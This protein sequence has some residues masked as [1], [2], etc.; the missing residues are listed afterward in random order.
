[1]SIKP[2][3]V[4]DHDAATLRRLMDS[5][6]TATTGPTR[7]ELT[8]SRS[9]VAAAQKKL[10]EGL[11]EAVGG[12]YLYHA[13]GSNINSLKNI[14]SNGLITNTSNQER[15]GSKLRALSFTR[16]WRY[17]LTKKDDD[18]QET[19]GI[20]NG[21]IFV[22][23]QSILKQKNKMQSVDR[24]ADIINEFK[25]VLAA[26]PTA[27]SAMDLFQLIDGSVTPAQLAALS[28][29]AGSSTPITNGRQFIS[30]VAKPYLADKTNQQA[31]ANAQSKIKQ[32]IS[33][34]VK[35]SAGKSIASAGGSTASEYEEVI[36]TPLNYVPFK[37]LGV[38]GYMI[39]PGVDS[40]N[41]QAIRNL[42]AKVGVNEMPIPNSIRPGK[43]VAEGS[44]EMDKV[45]TS[46]YKANQ[47]LGGKYPVAFVIEVLCPDQS[48]VNMIQN[49]VGTAYQ[50]ERDD[51]IEG[52]GI[53]IEIISQSFEGGQAAQAAYKQ[54]LDIIKQ[55]GGQFNNSTQV[56]IA[57]QTQGVTEA[58]PDVMRHAG[59][60]TIKIV[61]RAGKPIGEIGTDAEASSGNGAYYVKLYDGS[62][63]AVGFDTAEEALAELK[64][65]IK[66]GVTEGHGD[67]SRLE[68]RGAEYNVYFNTGKG[69][70]IARGT[71]QMKGQIAPQWFRTLDDAQEHAET[72]IG[73]Y[74]DKGV[75]E[76]VDPVAQLRADILRFSR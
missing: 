3:L 40:A 27:E 59:D 61:K 32:A 31:L 45:T 15:T 2:V 44:N 36:L 1:M 71:G 54:I 14:I 39:N 70:Y 33:Y 69:R 72:E 4:P 9:A 56:T 75:T 60:K 25:A 30:A 18:N 10:S 26:L 38:V 63:D 19:T 21:V 53:G 5:F 49:K 22:V 65:A 64:A 37:D 48:V 57:R 66:S 11:D 24:P 7:Q 23:D 62:Y 20:A 55:S 58:R 12:N 46:P 73:S 74:D 51:S 42:F 68:H 28:Q 16:N 52:N 6:A 17:A 76:S 29:I 67:A 50:V 43:G 8:E 35:T 41:Q 47:M 34:F 13:T